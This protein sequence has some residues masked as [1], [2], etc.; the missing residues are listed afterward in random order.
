[1][2]QSSNKVALVTGAGAG[3]GRACALRFATAGY[4]I[5]ALDLCE[6][7]LVL[8]QA[9][10]L[11]LDVDCEVQTGDI[12]DESTS[13]LASEKALKLWGRIDAL[14]ANAGIQTAGGLLSTTENDWDTILGVNLKGVAYSAK[15]CLP[16][17]IDKS[18]GSI[19]IISSINAFGGTAGMAIYDASKTAVLG[20]MRSLAIDHGK[21]GIRVNAVCP[22]NTLTDFHIKR[23]KEKGIDLDE[24]REMTRGY[25]LLDRAAEPPEIANAVYFLASEEASFIT[26]HTLIADGGYSI[27]PH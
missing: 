21:Q 20:L 7:D 2:T 11:K 16:T 23:M 18:Q 12:S 8:T 4:H 9:E 24:L 17:M 26:G 14:V 19:V 3:I 27:A 13:Q 25:A 1:M 5:L 10:I 6:A 22:G 15:A